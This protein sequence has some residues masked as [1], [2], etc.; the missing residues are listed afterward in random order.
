MTK[1]TKRGY[2]FLSNQTTLSDHRDVELE[3]LAFSPGISELNSV[4]D[5]P[6]AP[7]NTTQTTMAIPICQVGFEDPAVLHQHNT[8]VIKQDPPLFLNND[9]TV[10]LKFSSPTDLWYYVQRLSGTGVFSK[11]KCSFGSEKL[12][13]AHISR[14]TLLIDKYFQCVSPDPQLQYVFE[15]VGVMDY[16]TYF[17]FGGDF[18]QFVCRNEH[19]DG[20]LTEVFRPNVSGDR[21]NPYIR[22]KSSSVCGSQQCSKLMLLSGLR[23]KIESDHNIVFN[24]LVLTYP[25]EV[26]IQLLDLPIRDEIITRMHACAK[27]FFDKLQRIYCDPIECVGGSQSLHLCSSEIP[28]FP[29]AH[30]HFIFPH[31]KYKRV[32]NQYR[33]DIEELNSDLYDRARSCMSESTYIAKVPV[34][35][36]FGGMDLKTYGKREVRKITRTLLDEIT[37]NEVVEELSYR[38]SDQL[39]FTPLDWS[40]EAFTLDHVAI[41][42]WWT[43]IVKREFKDFWNGDRT[44]DVKLSY[45]PVQQRERLLHKL[46]YKTRPPVLD[47]DLFFRKCDGV[48]PSHNQCDINAI[49]DYLRHKFVESVMREYTDSASKYEALLNKCEYIANTITMDQLFE[50]IKFTAFRSTETR[51]Y[52]FWWKLKRY[53]IDSIVDPVLLYTKICPICGGELSLVQK[54]D[55]IAIDSIIIRGSSD[56]SVYDL[57]GGDG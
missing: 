15:S 43:K 41:K 11:Y 44:L 46:Q 50:F 53:M 32:Q 19:T 18:K 23:H 42:S 10:S 51:V 40:D 29:H 1:S 2:I 28:V 54:L 30:H 37:Y 14:S 3:D 22:Y 21:W 39:G 45:V 12:K 27:R 20:H 34:G 25:F 33:L 57:V 35:K 9:N 49:L 5:P 36:R 26:S 31:F 55:K 4:A 16:D 48:I 17:G 13:N 6:L 7:P 24:D 47:L 38:L 8:S 52:G 56:F